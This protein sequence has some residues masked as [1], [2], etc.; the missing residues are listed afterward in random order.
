MT[1]IKE[2]KGSIYTNIHSSGDSNTDEELGYVSSECASSHR[3]EVQN[4]LTVSKVRIELSRCEQRVQA[5]DWL[6]DISIGSL[7]TRACEASLS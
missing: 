3:T 6:T 1:E 7:E 5:S 2:R 4:F